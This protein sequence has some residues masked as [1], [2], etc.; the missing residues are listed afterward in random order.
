MYIVYSQRLY[1][2]IIHNLEY[3]S[4]NINLCERKLPTK[5]IYKIKLL[6][7]HKKH[8]STPIIFRSFGY[9]LYNSQ[10]NFDFFL[11]EVIIFSN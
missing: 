8:T 11:T 4:S 6:Y 9:R 2:N 1:T 3:N 10:E 5:I 7:Y